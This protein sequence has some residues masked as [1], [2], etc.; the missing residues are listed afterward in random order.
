[1]ALTVLPVVLG[2]P[3]EREEGSAEP[4]RDSFVSVM[5]LLVLMTIM[6]VFGI[7]VPQPLRELLAAA[8]G[9]L[10]GGQ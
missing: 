5:P 9:L 3:P 1:M 6:L 10:G 7:W 8:A 2:E 4:Y